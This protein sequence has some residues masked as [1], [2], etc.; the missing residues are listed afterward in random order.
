MRAICEA[1]AEGRFCILGRPDVRQDDHPRGIEAAADLA[2][3]ASDI[4]L[5]HGVRVGPFAGL[6]DARQVDGLDLWEN[7]EFDLKITS[8]SSPLWRRVEVRVTGWRFERDG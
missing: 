1:W 5:L 2:S 7:G 8:D 4:G 6:Y 3:F